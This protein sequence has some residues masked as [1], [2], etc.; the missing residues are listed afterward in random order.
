MKKIILIAV[1]L[2]SCHFITQAN[3][4]KVSNASLTGQNTASN[5]TFVNFDLSWEN[6]WRV[7]VGPT[8][9]DA[10]W[11]FIK[12]RVNNGPWTHS[13]INYVDGT[14]DGHTVPGGVSI[15]TMN[16]FTGCMIYRSTNGSGDVNWQ[17][18]QMRWNYGAN[19]VQDDD[20]VDIQVFALEMVYVPQG[21]FYVGG[22]SGDEANKFYLHPNTNNSYNITSE[23]AI[24][25]GATNGYLNYLSPNGG[26]GLGPIP[27]AYPKGFD[28]FYCMKY[29]MSEDQWV[30][31]FNSLSETQKANRDVTGIDGKNT[32]AVV[33]GN[34]VAW[35]GGSS[36]ATTTAP[37]RSIAYLTMGDML[38]YM[39]WAGLRPLSE[40]EYEKACRGPVFPKAGEF[41]WGNDNIY[42]TGLYNFSNQ[43]TP[44]EIVTNM[45]ISTGNA[46]YLTTTAG[47]GTVRC[48]I[49]GASATNKNREETG[50]SYYGIMELSGSNYERLVT[51]GNPRG[52][53]FTGVHGNGIIGSTGNSTAGGWPLFTTGEGGSYR[54]GGWINGSPFL[55]VSDRNDGATNISGGSSRIGVR[56][57]RTAP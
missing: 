28:A 19:G 44:S 2:T 7:A 39:D 20:V 40:L 30:C 55:R 38:A 46:S 29:E 56:C 35:S 6:S 13:R 12:H 32:D 15:N 11:I 52:R 24:D 21:S 23:V 49:F 3:N 10:A 22:T 5:F 26:D 31:F 37:D 16:D 34:T 51:V 41:A 1:I 57:G 8:N 43:G 53:L 9:Y 47:N 42:S 4:I 54:G 33:N 36:N 45:G 18:I 48:G 14:N 17:N 50:G 25:V 27:A